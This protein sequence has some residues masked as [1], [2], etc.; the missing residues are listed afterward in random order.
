M[1]SPGR[2]RT[3]AKL[4]LGAAAVFLLWSRHRPYTNCDFPEGT[5][6]EP[7]QWHWSREKAN[8]TYCIIHHL[9]D[10]EVQRIADPYFGLNE[11]VE[12]RS[13]ENHAL[14]YSIE[15]GHEYIVFTRSNDTLYI[16]D[17]HFN[18]SGCEVVAINLKTGKQLWKSSL[19]GIGPI[20]HF[21]YLNFVNI[22]TDGQRILVSGN[23]AG[24]RYV[25]LLDIMT[26]ETQANITLPPD[27]RLWQ[28]MNGY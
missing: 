8:L 21:E 13:K 20:D 9:P 11:R 12:F 2:W 14:P 26:G 23:E 24:G 1:I 6:H 19:H 17:Y 5:L 25:E 16:A 7:L 4:L 22:E 27:R 10:Y 28:S 15:S 3:A 18:S